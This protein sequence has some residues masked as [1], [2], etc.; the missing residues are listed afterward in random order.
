MSSIF[1]RCVQRYFAIHSKHMIVLFGMV[2]LTAA[3]QVPNQGQV[4][5]AEADLP[6]EGTLD[7][8]QGSAYISPKQRNSKLARVVV[9]RPA[10][11]FAKGVAHI[12]INGRHHTSLQLG[13]Y[14]EICIQPSEF[15]LAANMVD[16]D[17][18]GEDGS[19]TS[20]SMNVR[21]AKDIYLRVNENGDNRADITPVTDAVALAELQQTRRQIHIATRLADLPE[22][23][24]PEDK[25][26]PSAAQGANR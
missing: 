22:C 17:P 15:T 4:Q 25:Y 10:Q 7:R 2:V 23:I 21:A 24:E 18:A 11:G 13:G 6:G 26:A 9:Y 12:E 20:L 8:P 3:A 1:N 19:K 16:A 14:S 5:S